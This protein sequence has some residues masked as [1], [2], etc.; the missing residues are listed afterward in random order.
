M[1][2]YY[3]EWLDNSPLSLREDLVRL[4]E[5]QISESFRDYIKFGS[6]GIRAKR[7]VGISFINTYTISLFSLSYAKILL[8]KHKGK[9]QRE[10][11]IGHEGSEN[12]K[13]FLIEAAKV[14]SAQ[15]IKV[16]LFKYKK[17]ISAPIISYCIKNSNAIGGMYIGSGHN[18]N[19]YSG[20]NFFDSKGFYIGQEDIDK[21]YLNIKSI[22]NIFEIEKTAK[23]IIDIDENLFDHYINNILNVRQNKIEELQNAGV[24][25]SPLQGTTTTPISLISAKTEID[26]VITEKERHLVKNKTRIDYTN[27]NNEQ[28]FRRSISLAKKTNQNLVVLISKDG[29]RIGVASTENRIWNILSGNELSILQLAYLLKMLKKKKKLP[30]NSYIIKSFS[31]SKILNKIARRYNIKVIETNGKTR[32]LKKIIKENK[33]NNF[34]GYF[35]DQG[36]NFFHDSCIPDG[37]QNFLNVIDMHSY[38][39]KKNTTFTKELI[40]I[41]KNFGYYSSKEI[42]RKINSK[43]IFHDFVE[44][45]KSSEN[46]TFIGLEFSEI[47]DYRLKKLNNQISEAIEIKFKNGSNLIIKA[48]ET[49]NILRYIIESKSI[50]EISADHLSTEI[51]RNL[52]LISGKRKIIKGRSDKKGSKELIK[53]LTLLTITLAII[54]LVI[55][56]SFS[57]EFPQAIDIIFKAQNVGYFFL[58]LLFMILPAAIGGV[59]IY[60][61]G[62]N[63]KQKATVLESFLTSG[64]G[65]FAASISPMGIFAFPMQIWYLHKKGHHSNEIISTISIVVAITSIANFIFYLFFSIYGTINMQNLM[66]NQNLI[67]ILWIGTVTAF[68]VQLSF[69][70]LALATNI[71]NYAL[72]LLQKILFAFNK[73]EFSNATIKQLE[74]NIRSKKENISAIYDAKIKSVF[75]ILVAICIKFVFVNQLFISYQMVGITDEIAYFDLITISANTIAANTFNPLP[76]SSGT[77]EQYQVQVLT[78]YLTLSGFSGDI[79]ATANIITI[80]NRT[81]TFYLPIILGSITFIISIL[82]IRKNNNRSSDIS[83]TIIME[84]RQY[85]G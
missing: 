60:T 61:Y 39:F 15:G 11:V 6:S 67:N 22:K 55:W 46:Q 16:R 42:K 53:Y 13:E 27:P 38:F 20:F 79:S 25:F 34:L 2:S 37:I 30:E 5:E 3:Q 36:G 10:I 7:G 21:I 64:L 82:F 49:E 9:K 35:N 51:K 77:T 24:V 48:S 19:S 71:S 23:N 43:F 54:T 75:M 32:E 76:G 73:Y 44:K 12:S 31:A 14:F 33:K 41:Y 26:L 84:S 59:L 58:S 52:S 68:V 63:W 78:E 72:H 45:I 57:V 4:S 74:V 40:N 80:L 17:A 28:S 65:V 8:D 47:I 81:F 1:N 85:A 83:E 29:Q 70:F 69:I 50:S 18:D 62:K 56:N 66:F